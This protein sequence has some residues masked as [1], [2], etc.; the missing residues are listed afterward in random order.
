MN[1]PSGASR[2]LGS[3]T[4]RLAVILALTQIATLALGLGTMYA[5]TRQTLENNARVAA[6]VAA[7]DLRDE[8]RDGGVAAVTRAIEDRLTAPEDS[9]FVVL[10]RGADGRR[11]AGNLATWPASPAPPN[12]WSLTQLARIGADRAE[13][14]G[15][16]IQP[17][18]GGLTLLTG[19]VLQD[20]AQLTRASAQSFAYAM[21]AGLVIAALAS[22]VILRVLERRID[23]FSDAARDIASGRLNTRITLRTDG[24][25]FDR[26]G[27]SINAMLERIEAL[28]SELRAV[29][30]STAHDLR[31]PVARIRSSLERSFE[32]A[33]EPSSRTALAD[34]IDETD[35]L[36]RLLDTALEISRSEAGIGRSQFTQFDLAA[37]LGDLA[38]VY[39]P[40]AED[41]GYQIEVQSPPTLQVTAHRELLFRAVSNLIDNA[42]KYAAGGTQIRL[43]LDRT[44]SGAVE[45]SVTD[46]GPGILEQDREE[47]VRRFGRLDPAR[48]R[49]GAG[50]G[51]A[52]V[53]TTASLHGGTMQLSEASPRGLRVTLTLPIAA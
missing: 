28:V 27:V 47:A 9:H 7:G 19:E 20:Q 21:L 3:T 15:Y 29:T 33:K 10:L 53:S 52:L 5:L 25:A 24:D 26:L 18:P 42:L 41:E 30:D 8:Y 16:V 37:M 46:D 23:H 13:T 12:R 49:S 1:K 44:R 51:M 38:E 48:T 17:L 32:A 22:W 35:G 50:L 39:G 2:W 36:Q 14:T 45:L 4:W 43:S 34:A 31:S 40:L 6:E 11:L